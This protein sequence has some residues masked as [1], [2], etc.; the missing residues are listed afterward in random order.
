MHA[1]AHSPPSDVVWRFSVWDGIACVGVLKKDGRSW[2]CLSSPNVSDDTLI[3]SDA[4]IHEVG[5][6]YLKENPNKDTPF[7]TIKEIVDPKTGV[8]TRMKVK[9]LIH[10]TRPGKD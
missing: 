9:Q 10:A 7:K 5:K 1:M 3:D 6:K 8:V 2:N 4:S